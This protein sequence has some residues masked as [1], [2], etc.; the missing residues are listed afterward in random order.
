V[1]SFANSNLGDATPLAYAAMPP[2]LITILSPV[3]PTVLLS[4]I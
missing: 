4:P 3:P 2:E 1:P